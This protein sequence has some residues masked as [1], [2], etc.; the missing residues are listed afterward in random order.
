MFFSKWRGTVAL[1]RSDIWLNFQCRWAWP[2]EPGSLF[3]PRCNT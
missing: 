3:D 2:T 1:W